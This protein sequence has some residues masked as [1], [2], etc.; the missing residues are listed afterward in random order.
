MPRVSNVAAFGVCIALF[1][2]G[3]ARA[4]SVGTVRVAA[5]PEVNSPSYVTHAPDDFR[6]LFVLERLSGEIKI[7]D[8]QTGAFNGT[9][10]LTVP[11][12][13][14]EGLQGL[15]FHPDYQQ[16]GFFY[17]YFFLFDATHVVRY[18]RSSFDLADP[19]SALT[20]IDIAQP[21]TNHNGGWIGFGPDGYLYLPLGD[22]GSGHD[23]Q[24]HGQTIVNDLLSA[25]LR[26]D[27]DGDDFAGDPNR[28]YAI[29][30]DNFFVGKTG[31][32]EIWAYGLRNPFRSSFDRVTGDF[33]IGDVG[34]GTLEEI[35]FQPVASPGGENYGW[36][37]REGTIATPTG[38]VGGPQP[39]D[40]VDPIYEYAHGSGETE[41]FS[42]TGGY[43]YRGPVTEL[44]G[45]YFFAD[46]VNERIWSIRHDG[47]SVTEFI[48]WTDAFI[49]DVGSIGQIV[50]FGEDA[51][52]NLYIVDLGG[53]IFRVVG[54]G[55]EIPLFPGVW[56]AAVAA[57]LLFTTARA[58]VAKRRVRD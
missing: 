3:A 47:A 44:W 42:V 28:N 7:L 6:R 34:Q 19:N 17:V 27:V 41:G 21:F 31:D 33:Y 58:A 37:L 54:P 25:V 50:S 52:G 29:P 12:V 1:L 20:I 4:E 46:Y 5:A 18:T 2:G 48:D 35:N 45:R 15:A 10:F 13:S 51:R 32:N 23:P 22:G 39:S 11:M 16:N 53:E 24:N 40:G 26:L 9:P 36:R 49:P 43:V 38:G 14:G 8:L 55:S 30:T 56:V 57:L